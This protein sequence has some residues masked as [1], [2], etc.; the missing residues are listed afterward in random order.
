MPKQKDLKRVVRRRMRKTGESYT[1]AR[2]HVLGK[3]D[4]GA[5]K[6]KVD[7]ATLAGMS[8]EAIAAK[9]GCTWEKWVNHLDYFGAADKPHREIVDHVHGKFGI[10]GWWAQTVTVGYERIRG[11]RA[12][13]QRRSGSYETTKSKTIAVPLERLY[14]A[15]ADAKARKRWLGDV[16]LVVRKATPDKS[17]RITWDDGTSVEAGFFAKGPEKSMVAVAHT[18]LPDKARADELK[19]FWS[20]RLDALAAQLAESGA[21]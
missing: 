3:R 20:A 12:I 21:K 16:A 17:M 2:V 9:T 7:Y 6:A 14:A 19:R 11:L 8:D 4:G 1:S 5:K 10:P 18:K 15:F 13:G